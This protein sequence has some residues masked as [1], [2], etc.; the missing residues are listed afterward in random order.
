MSELARVFQSLE[1][2]KLQSETSHE[3]EIIDR[4]YEYF[5]EL[6]NSKHCK[7][8]KACFANQREVEHSSGAVWRP[9]RF[10]PHHPD[11]VKSSSNALKEPQVAAK[12]RRCKY[13]VTREWANFLVAE[14]DLLDY[15]PAF[16]A[17]TKRLL[18]AFHFA[19]DAPFP[20]VQWHYE[21]LFPFDEPIS[22]LTPSCLFNE[23]ETPLSASQEQDQDTSSQEHD[24]K[25]DATEYV[26][27]P[28]EEAQ[29]P[30][31]MEISVG[32][33][34]TEEEELRRHIVLINDMTRFLEEF[35]G[36]YLGEFG[37]PSDE[38]SYG[39]NMDMCMVLGGD[40]LFMDS[41]AYTNLSRFLLDRYGVIVSD[42]DLPG[43][44]LEQLFKTIQ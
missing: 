9:V 13:V 38:Q 35:R 30:E 34:D 15:Y 37:L 25:E 39:N 43:C 33:V 2:R 28:T 40:D 20:P 10:A 31:D 7:K 5:V 32:D 3:D 23:C 24:A 36:F 18:L 6:Q 27:I 44:T 26:N 41:L 42:E 12:R 16:R 21:R 1:F 11:V 17:Q 29:G 19:L 8:C 22:S 14:K 4:H